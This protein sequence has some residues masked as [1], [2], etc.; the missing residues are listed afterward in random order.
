MIVRISL[1]LL[2]VGMVG[3]AS[4]QEAQQATVYKLRNVAAADVV[5]ALAADAGLKKLN[6]TMVAEP[7]TNSVFVAGDGASQKRIAELMTALDKHLPSVQFTMVV[8]E[9]SGDFAKD[10]GLGEGDKWVL[11]PRESAMLSIAIR[12]EKQSGG[13]DVL[14]R[15]QLVLTDNQ[16]GFFEVFSG[17]ESFVVRA[18]PRISPKGGSILMRV[19]SE[20][21]K[22]TA[23]PVILGDQTSKPV[24]LI[25]HDTQTNEVTESVPTGNTLLIRAVLRK[26]QNKE[27]RGIFLIMTPTVIA[28][29]K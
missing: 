25:A 1:L 6:P 10:V 8:L 23:V 12:R 24:P 15:P 2:S 13:I 17:L 27:A 20:F 3:S 18:T 7:V 26:S 5:K 16:T 21:T 19:E 28:A 11:T 22:A 9:A 14:S 4:G 29:A